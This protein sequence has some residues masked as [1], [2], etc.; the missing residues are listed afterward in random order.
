M[1]NENKTGTNANNDWQMTG[2]VEKLSHDRKYWSLIKVRLPSVNILGK[3][4]EVGKSYL[5][6][7]LS[8][9]QGRY[10]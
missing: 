10:V 7:T 8:L 3:E 1:R 9:A 5:T 2:A 6:P 4:A